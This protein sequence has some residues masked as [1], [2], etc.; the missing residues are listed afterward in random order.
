MAAAVLLIYLAATAVY[1]WPLLANLHTHVANDLGDPLLSA[2]ILWW[3][4]TTL[5]FSPAWWNG[6]QYYPAQ[7]VSALTENMVGMWPV[8]MPT[9][10]LTGSPVVTYNVS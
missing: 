5:P 10:W 4:S 7:S 1:T 8:S 6:P 2:G 3:N 9:A